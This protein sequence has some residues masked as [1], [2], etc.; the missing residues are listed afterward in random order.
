MKKIFIF[1]SLV[2]F[3]SLALAANIP[4]YQDKYVNDF[5]SILTLQQTS[6]L[7]T[8]FAYIDENTTAEVVFVSSS[9]CGGDY[10]GYAMQIAET[11]KIGKADKD[12]GLLILYCLTEKKI[13][14]KTGYGLEGILPD[15]K[16]GRFL[17]QYYVPQRDAGNISQGIV[18]FSYGV[19]DEILKNREEI[20]SGQ[21]PKIDYFYFIFLF[22]IL[23]VIGSIIYT[24][25]KRDKKGFSDFLVFFFIDFLVRMIIYSIIFRGGNRSGSGGGFSGGGGFG[26]GGFG[27]GGASR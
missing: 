11:W 12:N 16:V 26:G 18:D 15:S 3:I 19:S 21:L 6:E 25:S 17:D 22:I 13:T 1:V 8:L 14:V 10:D 23:L 4:N 24:F 7:R 2:F 5:A 20:L 9:D 27:G